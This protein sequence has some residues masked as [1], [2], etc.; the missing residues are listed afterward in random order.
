MKIKYSEYQSEEITNVL[1]NILDYR[2]ELCVNTMLKGCQNGYIADDAAR[3]KGQLFVKGAAVI[4]TLIIAR[5]WF[6]WLFSS[7]IIGIT[8]GAI[9]FVLISKGMADPM[10]RLFGPEKIRLGNPAIQNHLNQY[11]VWD[12]RKGQLH[13]TDEPEFYGLSKFKVR[14]NLAE[15]DMSF[16]VLADALL[17]AANRISCLRS[18]AIA[19]EEIKAF[20]DRYGEENVEIDMKLTPINS[21]QDPEDK[22]Y[23]V[24]NMYTI[25]LREKSGMG[26]DTIV[27]TEYEEKTVH[28]PVESG[29]GVY[30]K[31]REHGILDLA[32]FDREYANAKKTC[33]TCKEEIPKRWLE[34]LFS[35]DSNVIRD[36]DKLSVFAEPSKGISGDPMEKEE[37]SVF[38]FPEFT[39]IGNDG[40][41]MIEELKNR[42]KPD[43]RA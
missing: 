4:A 30:T 38:R 20:V 25:T 17:G 33:E 10:N 19:S 22:T 40:A 39:G 37:E 26:G 15:G 24:S 23:S 6:G 29:E 2:D 18:L 34:P 8:I 28:I 12:D 43:N 21:I 3:R 7:G 5:V 35:Q 31:W 16:I 13:I 41:K 36:L 11:R 27:P 1:D 42:M 9:L 32:Y 14:K